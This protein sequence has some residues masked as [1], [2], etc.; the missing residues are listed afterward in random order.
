M[1]LHQKWV[2]KSDLL[3]KA[4]KKSESTEE[5]PCSEFEEDLVDLQLNRRNNKKS[6]PEAKSQSGKKKTPAVEPKCN[7]PVSEVVYEMRE[8][9]ARNLELTERFANFA[10][11]QSYLTGKSES[12]ILTDFSKTYHGKLF[13]P[14]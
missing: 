5:N 2:Q 13:T 1:D 7:Q 14:N 9:L 11:D 10:F 3:I 8:M 4:F 12:S 6:R